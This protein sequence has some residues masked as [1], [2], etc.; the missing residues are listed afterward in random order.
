MIAIKADVLE[1]TKPCGVSEDGFLWGS[2][3]VSQEVP[4]AYVVAH[5]FHVRRIRFQT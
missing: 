4:I 1:S 5:L 2:H 3:Y